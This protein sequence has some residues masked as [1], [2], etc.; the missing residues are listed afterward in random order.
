[1]QS[2]NLLHGEDL[3]L[4][5]LRRLPPPVLPDCEPCQSARTGPPTTN[6]AA[7]SYAG[8][9]AE[10]ATAWAQH[11]SFFAW[12]STGVK[13]LSEKECRE[14]QKKVKQLHPDIED[15]SADA[16]EAL[17]EKHAEQTKVLY[18]DIMDAAQRYA[19]AHD[20]DIV[21]HYN[22]ATTARDFWSPQNLEAKLQCRGLVAMY[23]KRG[24]DI[25]KEVVEALNY[26]VKSE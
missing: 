22:D 7:K 4:R 5:S 10:S 14:L 23:A 21:L 8:N 9:G 20:F 15:N 2:I 26:P 25:S 1:M 17:D 13:P 12:S 11:R 24:I 6:G 16:K 18:Q 19:K 3:R